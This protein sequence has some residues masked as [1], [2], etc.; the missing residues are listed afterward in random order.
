MA[1]SKLVNLYFTI[2]HVIGHGCH[3]F[4]H[5]NICNVVRC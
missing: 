3:V 4:W 2:L 5:D 1:T